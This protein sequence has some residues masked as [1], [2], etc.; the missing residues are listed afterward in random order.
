MSSGSGY[1]AR[2][3]RSFYLV[4]NLL[5]MRRGAV[6]EPRAHERASAAVVGHAPFESRSSKPFAHATSQIGRIAHER[7]AGEKH[8]V[9]RSRL[10]RSRVA[11]CDDFGIANAE[12]GAVSA[13]DVPFVV[14]H[15]ELFGLVEPR[16]H[17]Q[18]APVAHAVGGEHMNRAVGRAVAAE[19]AAP[20]RVVHVVVRLHELGHRGGALVDGKGH[21]A[22]VSFL[23]HAHVKARLLQHLA[24]KRATFAMRALHFLVCPA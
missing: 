13:E 7:A 22:L 21:D 6:E 5:T 19:A 10:I 9:E 14:N 23:N 24:A 4:E 1:H 11:Q 16:F 8:R 2:D 15:R 20:K 17:E 3:A 18:L 12:D